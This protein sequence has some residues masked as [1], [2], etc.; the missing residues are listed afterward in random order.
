MCCL[1]FEP[2]SAIPTALAAS[3]SAAVQ[4]LYKLCLCCRYREA[5]R[6]GCSRNNGPLQRQRSGNSVQSEHYSTP[7]EHACCLKPVFWARLLDCLVTSLFRWDVQNSQ[8]EDRKTISKLRAQPGGGS[9]GLGR[10]GCVT[11]R[12]L[13]GSCA[14]HRRTTA[15]L[16]QGTATHHTTR[17]IR[18]PWAVWH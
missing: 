18:S 17:C 4:P 5:R 7:T 14:H 1:S 6:E 11:C 2:R 8:R 9:V 16:A 15:A 12:T 13:R 10:A 3:C